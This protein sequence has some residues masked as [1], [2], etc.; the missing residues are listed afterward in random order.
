MSNSDLGTLIICTVAIVMLSDFLWQKSMHERLKERL[1][2]LI[3][4]YYGGDK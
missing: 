2:K 4:E 3:D 1:D